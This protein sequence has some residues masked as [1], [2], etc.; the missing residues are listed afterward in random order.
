MTTIT[1]L[2]QLVQEWFDFIDSVGG[3]YHI[4]EHPEKRDELRRLWEVYRDALESPPEGVIGV[5]VITYAE[6]CLIQEQMK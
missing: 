2:D 3:V 1:S 5:G 6:Q 4:D